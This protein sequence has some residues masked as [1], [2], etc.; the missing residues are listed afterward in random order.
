LI[1]TSTK[2]KKRKSFV[3]YV[4]VCSAYTAELWY[5]LEGLKYAWHR[6]FRFLELDVDSVAAVQAIK[7]GATTSV[8]GISMIKSI[9]R[10]LDQAWEVKIVHSYIEANSYA[11]ALVNTGCSLHLNIVYF[12]K[13]PSQVRH[14]F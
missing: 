5:V 14:L 10:L 6:G 12:D 2:T 4:G 3:K 1:T 11:D 8:N 13:C 9:C 7:S